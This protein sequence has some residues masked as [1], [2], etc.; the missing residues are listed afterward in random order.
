MNAWDYLPNAVHIDRILASVKSHPDAWDQVW[1][2]VWETEWV[3]QMVQHFWSTQCQAAKDEDFDAAWIAV[4]IAA[5][6]YK[7]NDLI[8]RHRLAESALLAL[9][10]YDDCA[11]YLDLTLDQL[12]VLYL[13]NEHPACLL[14]QPA[15]K[16]FVK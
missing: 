16:V 11:K 9:L 7:E 4:T 8:K 12:K 1:P 10:V 2:E 13:L 15:V 14:L 6:E 5:R 3:D